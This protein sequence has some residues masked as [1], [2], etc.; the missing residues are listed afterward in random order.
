MLKSPQ[1][2]R[3]CGLLF[4]S[5]FD[6]LYACNLFPPV[7]FSSG[8]ESMPKVS[9]PPKTERHGKIEAP[10][11]NNPKVFFDVSINEKAA[12]RI[13]MELYA[14]TVPRTAENFRA[15]CTGE[16]GRGKS[17]K[18]LHYKGC[19]FHRVIPGFMLQGGDITRGNGTGG[20]SIYG[21]T[22]RD[23]S[24]AGKAGKH[25]GLGCLSMAN[26]GPNTNGSQFFICTANTPW[27][28]GKHV[29]FGRVTEGIDVVKSIERLGSDSGKTR[30]RIIIANCGELQTQKEGAAKKEK[31]KAKEGNNAGKLSTIVEGTGGAKRPREDVEDLE[32][33]KKRIREKRERI[34]KLRAQAE[35]K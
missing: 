17:G 13:V 26:A 21:T 5:T 1:N 29:V 19:I 16:K 22:F 10:D 24:F 20:E 33:R 30:G 32:E 9:V 4:V 18:P 25:T 3:K 11:T 14:D 12:G 15:L 31:V 35:E 27:L 23:E 34:A 7:L 8:K 6:F 28:N 2:F